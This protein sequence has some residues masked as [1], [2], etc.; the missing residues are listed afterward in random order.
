MG[1]YEKLIRLPLDNS[2]FMTI[3][4]KPKFYKF[5]TKEQ[6]YYTR[7]T[8]AGLLVDYTEDY[9]LVGEVTE[10]GNIHYHCWAY[11]SNSIKRIR[12][13]NHLKVKR[14][15]G[16]VKITPEPIITLESKNRVS[17]YLKK[18]IKKTITL[19]EQYKE[20]VITNRTEFVI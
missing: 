15:I 16:Y 19:A 3:T 4:I 13:L 10:A 9:Q 7:F 11:F 5:R 1:E 20:Y 12:C 18:D 6:L 17:E 8:V 2:Y 14:D